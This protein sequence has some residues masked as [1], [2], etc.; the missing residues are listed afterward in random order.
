[1][2]VAVLSSPW[3]VSPDRLAAMLSLPRIGGAIADYDADRANRRVLGVLA[4]AH[5]AHIGLVDSFRAHVQA[6]GGSGYF[7]FDEHWNAAGHAL[8]AELIADGL[9]AQGL[10]PAGAQ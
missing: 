10:V 8:A 7:D 4:R 5:V 6:T 3:E 2:V 9:R 1:L